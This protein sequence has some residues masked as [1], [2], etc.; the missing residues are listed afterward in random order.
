MGRGDRDGRRGDA[1]VRTTAMARTMEPVGE[2]ASLPARTFSPRAGRIVI[3]VCALACLLAL[4]HLAQQVNGA[5]HSEAGRYDFSSYYAAGA[6]LRANPH[7][8]I[9]SQSVLSEVGRSARLLVNPP[10]PYTYPP[11]FAIVLSPFTALS[12]RLLSRVWLAAS[13]ALWL[14]VIPILAVEM[15]HL[16]APAIR[17]ALPGG[18]PA[19]TLRVM[20]TARNPV[21]WIAAALAVWLTLFSWP[22]AQ[23]MSTGQVNFLVLLPLALVPLLT[24]LRHERWVGV[25]IAIAAMLKFT[26]ALL[27]GYL[28]LRRRWGALIASLVTLLA[29]AV[30][31]ALVVGPH[32][33]LASIPQALR[34]GGGDAGQGHNQALFAPLLYALGAA[35]SSAPALVTRAIT[36]LG[37]LALAVW[38]F[39]PAATKTSAPEYDA[40]GEN[41]GYAL[42]LC[43]M[44]LISPTAWVHHYVWI[45]PAAALAL[46]TALR[47][48]LVAHTTIQLRRGIIACLLIILACVGL[49]L[50]LPGN[51]DTE[52]SPATRTF[53]G[54]RL[55]PMLLEMRPLATLLLVGLL[56]AWYGRTHALQRGEREAVVLTP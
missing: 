46:G 2:T 32:T 44:V 6:A 55:W 39:R 10:L 50:A 34:V 38:L 41:L 22:A 43:A 47:G 19:T 9:Y 14:A 37:A 51:W 4:G 48:L 27:I 33:L 3:M 53:L 16:I 11:L 23:T 8:N 5:F 49:I 36:G 20:R 21:A 54:L 24:R 18:E 29:L 13:F 1:R 7:A 42:A 15:Y 45:L 40:D 26:P 17:F 31:S 12:F 35:P 30:L 28:A 25:A 52:P 56:C